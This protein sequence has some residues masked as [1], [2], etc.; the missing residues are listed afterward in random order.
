MVRFCASLSL[1]FAGLIG[2]NTAQAAAE[3]NARLAARNSVTADELHN[4]AAVLADDTFEGREAGSRGGRAAAGYILDLLKKYGLRG[5]GVDGAYTQPF[6]VNNRNILAVLPGSDSELRGEI[7]L[8]GAHYD[9]VGYGT[10]SNSYGPVGYIHNGADDNA[11]G[12]STVLEAAQ[13]LSMLQGTHRRTILIA[14]WDGEEKGLVGSTHWLRE[15]T[16]DR[17]QIKCTINLDMVGRLRDDHL[18]IYGTRALYGSRKLISR[19]NVSEDLSLEFLWK[20][21]EDSDHYPF[22]FR[23]I[24]SLM[25]H[26][27]KHT[28]YHR[29]SD[30]V[31]KLNAEG[32]QRIARLLVEVVMD[33][34]D[35]DS[36][37]SFRARAQNESTDE[38]KRDEF[39]RPLPPAPSRLGLRWKQEETSDDGILVAEVT[40]RSPAWNAGIRPGDRLITWNGESLTSNERFQHLVSATAKPVTLSVSSP[41]AK[42]PREVAVVLE[43]DPVRIGIAWLRDE[44]EPSVAMVRRIYPG[45]PAALAGVTAGDR[46]YTVDDSSFGSDA[47]FESLLHAARGSTS[48]VLERDGRFRT[49]VLDVGDLMAD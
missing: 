35:A 24:P 45:S 32:M 42:E 31:E 14:F 21:S 46:I 20:M 47:E 5:G 27:G 38:H 36:I 1:L 22:Y 19:S 25:F 30:D 11:S 37:P 8:V 9:H 26:T 15:P 13:A 43:G 16:F 7:I 29:P 12:V 10:R 4:H 18:E 48:L 2:V 44:A 33:L 6:G 28:D 40:R 17:S 34:A 3:L 41:G 39:E 49:V 23:K